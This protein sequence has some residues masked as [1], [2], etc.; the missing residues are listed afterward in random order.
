MRHEPAPFPAV[1]ACHIGEHAALT[2]LRIL[3]FV[4]PYNRYRSHTM[5][6]PGAGKI[7]QAAG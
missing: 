7:V 4:E 1:F 3:A 6:L 2:A 5:I